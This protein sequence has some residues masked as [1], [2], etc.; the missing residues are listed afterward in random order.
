M[1]KTDFEYEVKAALRHKLSPEDLAQDYM[2]HDGWTAEA[3]SNY[4]QRFNEVAPRIQKEMGNERVRQRAEA[5]RQRNQRLIQRAMANQMPENPI[6]RIAYAGAGALVTPLASAVTRPFSSEKADKLNRLN[7]DVAEANVIAGKD[8]WMPDWID[9]T[10]PGAIASAG[11]AAALA[12][13]GF[14]G[15][16]LGFGASR[17]N[18][19]ITEGKDAGLKGADLWRYAGTAGAIEGGIMTA[20][21]AVGAGG[22]EKMLTGGITKSGLKNLLKQTGISLLQELPEENLTELAD[23]VN[24]KLAGV[25][26]DVLTKENLWNTFRDTT[27]QTVMTMGVMGGFQGALSQ[28]ALKNQEAYAAEVVAPLYCIE[29]DAALRAVQ[30]AAEKSKN[31]DRD[32][33]DFTTHLAQTAHHER[34]KTDAGLQRWVDAEPEQAK[35]LAG[36]PRL[37]PEV[38]EETG[39][40]SMSRRERARFQRRL[41]NVLKPQ[42][43]GYQPVDLTEEIEEG[44]AAEATP[45]A[46]ESETTGPSLQSPLRRDTRPF[47]EPSG[48]VLQDVAPTAA[49]PVAQDKPVDLLAEEYE[50]DTAPWSEPEEMEELHEPDMAIAEEPTQTPALPEKTTHKDSLTVQGATPITKQPSSAEDIEPVVKDSLTTES[51]QSEVADQPVNTEPSEAQKEAGNYKMGHIQRDGLDISIENPAGSVRRGKDP[52]GKAWESPI[53]HDYGYI[54]GTE[55]PDKDHVDVFIKPGSKEGGTVYVVNQVDPNTKKFDEPKV[56]M[57]FD[58]Q[59]EASEAYLSN[60][61]PGWQGLDT[62]VPM[63][64]DEFKTWVKSDAAKKGPAKAEAKPTE[65]QPV[66]SFTVGEHYRLKDGRSVEIRAHKPKGN[67]PGYHYWGDAQEIFVRYES[68]QTGYVHHSQ[69]TQKAEPLPTA[70]T[71][72]HILNYAGNPF[73][74]RG[75]TKAAAV[76]AHLSVDA[77]EQ[78]QGGWAVKLPQEGATIQPVAKQKE[79]RKDGP[80]GSPET[81]D[82]RR[83]DR[84]HAKGTDSGRGAD[85]AGKTGRPAVSGNLSAVLLNVPATEPPSGD[86][87]QGA[88]VSAKAVGMER[89]SGIVKGVR[90]DH[91]GHSSGHGVVPTASE[92]GD[93]AAGAVGQVHGPGPVQGDGHQQTG[94]AGRRRA[95]M[96]DSAVSSTGPDNNYDLRT[97]APIKL[98]KGQRRKIN[99]QARDILAKPAKDITESDRDVLRQYTGEGGLSAGSR[100]ALNQHYTDYPTIRAIFQALEKAK[101]PMKKA[102]EP[103]AGSGNFVGNRPDLNW[104][105]VDI[106]ETNHKVVSALYP[107]GK[108]YYASY[109]DFTADG[110]DLVISNVPFL[111]TRGAGRR[112]QRPDIKA[113]HDFYFVHSLERVKPDG[114]IAFITS[115]GTMDKLDSRIRQEVVDKA[116]IIGAFRLP[117]G[118]FE[119]NA[120]TS[121]TTDI[122]FMQRRPDGVPA[123]P[124][125]QTRN[126]LFVQSSK[127][128]DDIALNEWYQAHPEVVL[129]KMAAGKSKLY[130]GR[131]AYEVRGPALLDAIEV[132]YAPYGATGATAQHTAKRKEGAPET[133]HEFVPWAKDNNVSFR[134]SDHTKFS[135]NVD[136]RDG[137]VYAATEEVFFTDLGHRAKIY[138]PV[139][140]VTAQKILLLDKIRGDA[141]RFQESEDTAHADAG[142]DAIQA[143]RERFKKAPIKDRTLKAFFKKHEEM[144]FFAE[145][146]TLF[147]EEFTP[148]P[149]FTER[150]RYE[151]SGRIQANRSSDLRVRAV[152]A[153]NARGEVHFPSALLS[154]ADIPT[155]LETGYALAGLEDGRPVLQNEILFYSGN[156]YEKAKKIE[157]IAKEMPQYAEV[158]ERQAA[159]LNDLKPTPKS[160]D[161]IHIKG[162]ETWLQPYLREIGLQVKSTINE[163]TGVRE[164]H[165]LGGGEMGNIL[166]RHMNN[167]ALVTRENIAENVQESMTSYMAR[168]REAEALLE[169]A[170][171][172]IKTQIVENPSLCKQIEFEYNRRFRNYVKPDY[173]KAQYLIQDVLDEISENSP[174]TLRKNQVRWVIQALYEG[175]GINAHDVGGGKTMA[176]IVLARALKKRGRAQ[177][178]LFVVPAKTIKKWVRETRMLFPNAK[179]VDLGNL[180][181]KKRQEQ[182]FALSNNNADFVYISHEGYGKIKLPVAEEG[183]YVQD[184]MNEHVDDPEAKGRQEGLLKEKMEAYVS[185]LQ[186][187]G[188]DTRLTFDKLGFDCVIADEA[189]AFKNLGVNNQLCRFG[190]GISFGFNKTGQALKSARSYDFRFKANY[191]TDHNNG[192]NVFLLTATPTPNKPMEIYTMLRHLGRNIF[193]DYGLNTDRD[194]ADAFFQLGTVNDAAKNRP[195]NILKAI[196]NAIELRGLLNRFVDKVSME[197]MPW[198]RVP[199]INERHVILE[200]SEG[201]GEVNDDMRRRLA[202][203]P[204]NPVEGDDTHIAIYTSGRSSSTDPRLY[205]GAHAQVAIEE[206]SYNAEDDKL[207]WTIEQVA[208]VAQENEA[209]GQLIFL[210]DS[211]HSQVERGQLDENLHREIKRELVSMGMEPS[212]SPLST[213][214]KSPT[215]RQATNPHRARPTKRNRLSQTPTTQATSKSSSAPPPAWAKAWTCKS[216]PPTSTTS[217]FPTPPAHFVNATD[218]ACVPAMRM[219]PS[220][221]IT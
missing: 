156:V 148:A 76:R 221:C 169:E 110:F 154:E 67:R 53:H 73:K 202:A 119:A 50:E 153:E 8:D 212:R 217:T 150:T 145:L 205:S 109:E 90:P 6:A 135:E 103:A 134:L 18:Q 184:A 44:A 81:S 88:G 25:S 207:Q 188:R 74:N 152:A 171:E 14:A 192:G 46:S 9:R 172:K 86:G 100:E 159:Q 125:A 12:P 87:V 43:D 158:L 15:L 5:S 160:V 31:T 204:S 130:G 49:R 201:Q 27:L 92:R 197:S 62:I 97:A 63:E 206:R 104:T 175:R 164:Y 183:R 174:I 95:D 163:K 140:G 54:R 200:Q 16:A 24:Q 28:R 209:A 187:D 139:S 69:L 182:L 112:K 155:L 170:F 66:D 96:R 147:N 106:D 47:T 89:Q 7:Q 36:K 190:L 107:K 37:T 196:V 57:G 216:K 208:Q 22:L 13:T 52:N 124:D 78:V 83:T 21:Q 55:G 30:R 40:P 19:A 26:P 176:A 123:R 1:P 210:D 99:A 143:Y 70:T 213:A 32:S 126:E 219:T 142:M 115:T 111:E 56:M 141:T 177:K 59:K 149:V 101:V 193:D 75:P 102:L 179:I 84:L 215:S 72:S 91:A 138:T 42:V 132:D 98:T 41:R 117:G 48:Q 35:E 10:A 94:A 129:G 45:S 120:H 185:A 194:F 68:G 114:V 77:V 214:R 220:T 131:P 165:V 108:H 39:L 2:E 64:P 4:I 168:M 151:D 186:E 20:F 121:V 71:E 127:T 180:S 178:P 58:S 33:D 203:L 65:E 167:R 133:Y 128:V 161:E 218:A 166:E 137:V 23:N 146:S 136:V 51:L 116:D 82:Q 189:H 157:A 162:T 122:I 198:I 199:Q 80:S 211:G 113:L 195:K 3:A 118:H 34:L 61:E 17:A 191:I 93:D 11:Q 181:K 29:P 38:L 79:E 105:T 60:Y 85:K 144:V 173:E